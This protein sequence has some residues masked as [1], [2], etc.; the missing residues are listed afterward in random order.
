MSCP[1]ISVIIP[2]Y[3]VEDYLDKCLQ[4]VLMN[5]YSELE[6]I[7][8]N[9]GSTDSSPII[10]KKWQAQDPRVIVVSHENRGLPEA[11]NSGLEVMTG[12]YTAFID[13]DDWV[14]PQYFQSLFDCMEETGADMVVSG[15]RRFREDEDIDVDPN[16]ELRRKKLSA[17]EFYKNFYARYVIWGRL[18]R[19]RDT[20]NLRFP[21][22]VDANQDNLYNLKLIANWKQP[23]VYEIDAPL[24]YYL[25][26]PKS[27][28][29][30]RS[31]E[32]I[33]Q[34]SNWY[35]KYERDPY[36]EKTGEWGRLLLLNSIS[37]T[38]YC[39]D[40]AY[41]HKDREVIRKSNALLKS[42]MV[43]L[44]R[45]KTI[46]LHDKLLLPVKILFPRLYRCFRVLKVRGLF[47]NS[48][49]G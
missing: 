4:S 35:V 38:M 22:E 29:K 6:V 3:N 46:R 24:Y 23:N 18:L 34:I 48:A 42:M 28:S 16:V 49:E 13:A 15:V 19:R 43:D 37:K 5:T 9:D 47:K 31:Y 21:P 20:K 12:D 25:D 1:R 36:H 30:L 14:H 10:L 41:A 2:V 45:D 40:K 33:L 27:L 7:C 17:E 44:L 11:R 26:R 39:R 8:V 32:E